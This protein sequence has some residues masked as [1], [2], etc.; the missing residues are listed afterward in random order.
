LKGLNMRTYML[1]KNLVEP[2]Q[3]AQQATRWSCQSPQFW[4]AK[5]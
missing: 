3:A 1:A 2:A 4:G 5:Y